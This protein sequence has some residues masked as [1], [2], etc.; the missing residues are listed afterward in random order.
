M[1]KRQLKRIRPSFASR[2]RNGGSA[3]RKRSPPSGDGGTRAPSVRLRAPFLWEVL[4]LR[5]ILGVRREES[6]GQQKRA[7]LRPLQQ[8]VEGVARV[9][10]RDVYA[11]AVR[12]RDPMPAVIGAE[13]IVILG[14]R[15]ADIVLAGVPR[16]VAGL[17]QQARIGSREG[18]G[19]QRL[20]EP[21]DAVTRHVL[22]GEQRRPAH[23]ADCCG[24][25]RLGEPDPAGRQ[26]IQ[27]GR[28]DD[29]IARCAERVPPHVVDHQHEDVHPDVHLALG[30]GAGAVGCRDDYR[31]DN[32]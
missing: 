5:G 31:A 25:A 24:D 20:A 22:A 9:L 3:L 12:L 6:D 1:S 11:C 29:P 16:P 7:V 14:S 8:E 18:L 4:V 30:R 17:P 23:H 32:D 2:E 13:E 27:A 19:R 21:I 26:P 15:R 10:L 28:P